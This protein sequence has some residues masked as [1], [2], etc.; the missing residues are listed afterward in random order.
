MLS[1]LEEWKE[2]KLKTNGKD[3]WEIANGLS[4]MLTGAPE[5]RQKQKQKL[6]EIMAKTSP[7]LMKTPSTHWSSVNS[8]K[9]KYKENQT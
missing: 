6:Q 3:K 2:N 9:N 4:N 8:K 1:K 7:N 5:V